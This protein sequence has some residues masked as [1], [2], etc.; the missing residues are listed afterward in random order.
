MVEACNALKPEQ[1]IIPDWASEGPGYAS[2][3]TATLSGSKIRYGMQRICGCTM[4]FVVSRT[5]V[6][7]GHYWESECFGKEPDEDYELQFD[8]QVTDF[9]RVGFQA[10][11]G[12]GNGFPSLTSAFLLRLTRK[13][14]AHVGLL[15]M[16]KDHDCMLLMIGSVHTMHRNQKTMLT[17]IEAQDSLQQHAAD[18]TNDPN[19]VVYILSP[20][21]SL[22]PAHPTGVFQY[23]D[24]INTMASTVANVLNIPRAKVQTETYVAV[25]KSKDEE[26][27]EK[28]AILETTAAGHMIFDY[29]PAGGSRRSP[30]AQWRI[31]W[32]RAQ[33]LGDEW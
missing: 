14:F 23:S 30:M 27:G 13:L 1:S 9:L 25:D 17:D 21:T 22:D 10:P 5:R 28:Q 29:D 32:Q 19:L 4:L 16:C 12:P 6:Y 8:E 15:P 3:V 33:I 31:I 7:L 18:F 2:A 20:D 24:E 11:N 26:K